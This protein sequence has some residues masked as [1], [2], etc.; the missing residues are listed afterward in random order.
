VELHQG[1]SSIN[2]ACSWFLI[3]VQGSSWPHQVAIWLGGAASFLVGIGHTVGCPDSGHGRHYRGVLHLHSSGILCFRSGK[4]A[5]CGHG[6]AFNYFVP[7]GV[8]FIDSLVQSS[9]EM[10]GPF[11]RSNTDLGLVVSPP[12][13]EE[14]NCYFP[15]RVVKGDAQ[16]ADG[17]AVPGHLWIH[18]F[19]EGNAREGEEA[20]SWLHL[21]ALGLPDHAAVGHLRETGPPSQEANVGQK[22]L[23]C[24]ILRVLC[25]QSLARYFSLNAMHDANQVLSH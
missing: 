22:L 7:G 10:A 5:F 2:G 19:L 25:Y 1:A 12:M 20:D 9:N 23:N 14:E 11:T 24:N 4:G 18:A 3:S 21:R 15:T 16:K 13:R 17:A 8:F 6:R